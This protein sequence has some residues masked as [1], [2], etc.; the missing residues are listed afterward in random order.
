MLLYYRARSCIFLAI[1]YRVGT[2]Y[3]LRTILYTLDDRVI[4]LLSLYTIIIVCNNYCTYYNNT[5]V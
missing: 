3:T 4:I 5:I 2:E 1:I